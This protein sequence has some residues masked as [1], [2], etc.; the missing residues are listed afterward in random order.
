VGWYR[1]TSREGASGYFVV[2]MGL[3]GLVAGLIIG[4]IA[5]AI[6][7]PETVSRFGVAV[8]VSVGVIVVLALIAAVTSRVLA[9]V[10]PTIDGES[11]MLRLEV[12]QP[13]ADFAASPAG[14]GSVA[15]G[16]LGGRTVRKS[17][18][19]P[20]W[21]E[22]VAGS[23][24]FQISFGAVEI[25]TSRGK[26]LLMIDWGARETAGYFL[27]LRAF[28]GRKFF[29]WS[30]WLPKYRAGVDAG[31]RR[32]YRFRIQKQY[33]PI[34]RET[35]GGFEIR[36]I[37]ERFV[38]PPSTADPLS[39]RTK[40]SRSSTTGRWSPARPSETPGFPIRTSSPPSRARP[41]SSSMT[42]MRTTLIVFA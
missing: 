21:T 34:R 32:T 29:N 18:R 3:L 2:F 41:P 15:L 17:V 38:E 42:S 27:P 20:L 26:R 16:S 1:I 19:G 25:F 9:D 40:D 39:S 35:A 31:S 4:V 13:V 11:P 30:D 7:Q 10:P 12:R 23:P 24:D 28:P 37:A 5:C 36:T 14:P 33:D 6:V 22:P 8:G